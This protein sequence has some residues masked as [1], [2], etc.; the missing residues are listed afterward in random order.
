M[1]PLV[2]H[3]YCL[4]SLLPAPRDMELWQPHL[5]W[6]DSAAPDR[7]HINF[8]APGGGFPADDVEDS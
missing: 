5:C 7:V 3:T 1:C 4:A 8:P 6:S 2:F